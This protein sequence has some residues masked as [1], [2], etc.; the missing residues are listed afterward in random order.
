MVNQKD[1]EFKNESDLFNNA[2]EGF[3]SHLKKGL[4]GIYHQASTKH[5]CKYCNEFAFR[6]NIR[7]IS[8]GEKFNAALLRAEKRLT[9]QN[10]INR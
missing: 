7:K 2:I 9:Y 5:L 3:G 10:L 1:D 6:Y 4:Y 8:D